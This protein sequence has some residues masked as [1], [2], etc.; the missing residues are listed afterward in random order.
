MGLLEKAK[1]RRLEY[2]RKKIAKTIAEKDALIIK[3]AN[4]SKESLKY[5]NPSYQKTYKNILLSIMLVNKGINKLVTEITKSKTLQIRREKIGGVAEIRGIN[6]ALFSRY[7]QEKN[8]LIDLQ[9]Q[10]NFID[11]RMDQTFD[12]VKYG[13]ALKISEKLRQIEFYTKETRNL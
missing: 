2:L 11:K 5:L 8:K 4:V 7:L 13:F 1:E 3:Q 10:K 6:P 12:I 9:K